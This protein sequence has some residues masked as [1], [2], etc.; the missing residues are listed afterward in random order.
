MMSPT[1]ANARSSRS[2]RSFR[3]PSLT[4]R[5]GRGRA[6]RRP[7]GR[8]CSSPRSSTA[9]LAGPR[10]VSP[11]VASVPSSTATD[12][13]EAPPARA[14][15]L[16]DVAFAVTTRDSRS[17]LPRPRRRPRGRP[18]AHALLHRGARLVGPDQGP[19][20]PRRPAPPGA[21]PIAAISLVDAAGGH[22]LVS[23]RTAARLS[24]AEPAARVSPRGRGRAT[25]RAVAPRRAGTSRRGRAGRAVRCCGRARRS[26]PPGR[27]AA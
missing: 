24:G 4:R 7:K 12:P 19:H 21:T 25:A 17:C 13:P 20:G 5:A 14:L 10:A 11:G 16:T 27:A 3:T 2:P 8:P 15:R 6:S 23:G 26:S 1:T 22:D 18:L 9:A